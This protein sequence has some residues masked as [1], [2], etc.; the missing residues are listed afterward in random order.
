M[1]QDAL[2]EQVVEEPD[3][4]GHCRALLQGTGYY[5]ARD[6]AKWIDIGPSDPYVHPTDSHLTFAY[7]RD[8]AL[9]Q[10]WRRLGLYGI[11][12]ADEVTFAPSVLRNT[13]NEIKAR[14]LFEAPPKTP[15]RIHGED[16]WSSEWMG[17]GNDPGEG[18]VVPSLGDFS[19]RPLL[20][21]LWQVMLMVYGTMALGVGIAL[22]IIVLWPR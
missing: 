6:P 2:A 3:T 17:P 20:R 5:V 7:G 10:V 22:A 19:T 14:P 12:D 4:V 1:G 13:L 11:D 21:P 18:P 8:W 16:T 9:G 15:A